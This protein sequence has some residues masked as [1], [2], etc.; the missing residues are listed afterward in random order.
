MITQ[1]VESETHALLFN[2]DM[3]NNLNELSDTKWIFNKFSS[4]DNE[5]MLTNCFKDIQGPY[6][7]IFYDKLKGSIYFARD[8]L[9]RNSLLIENN[10]EHFRILS[11]SCKLM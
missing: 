11:T 10:N 3:F 9:G 2:G 5:N 4:A 7:I 8:P 1:P 6:S